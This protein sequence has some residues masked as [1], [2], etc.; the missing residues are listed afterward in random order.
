MRVNKII[1]S[2]KSWQKV[3]DLDSR[4]I[5]NLFKRLRG[6]EEKKMKRKEMNEVILW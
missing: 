4:Q 5:K 6:N 2:K 1:I 3:I